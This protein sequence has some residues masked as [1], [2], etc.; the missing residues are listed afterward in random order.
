MENKRPLFVTIICILGFIGAPLVIVSAL[1]NLDILA[2]FVSPRAIIP[3]WYLVFSIGWAILYFIALIF[4]WKMRKIGL[5][6]YT[7]L[8]AIDYIVQFGAGL[9]PIRALIYSTVEIG[10]LWIYYKKMS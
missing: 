10:L 5:T 9:S 3:S 4:I 8:A 6:T 2:G 1:F 7:G